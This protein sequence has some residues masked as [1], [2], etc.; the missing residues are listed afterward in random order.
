MFFIDATTF[1]YGITYRIPIDVHSGAP[2]QKSRSGLRPVYIYC[3]RLKARAGRRRV[4]TGKIGRQ[5]ADYS[6]SQLPRAGQINPISPDIERCYTFTPRLAFATARNVH[7]PSEVRIEQHIFIV[8]RLA[9]LTFYKCKL[10]ETRFGKKFKIPISRFRL[11]T[12]LQ[13]KQ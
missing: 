9:I 6:Y 5:S 11:K 10:F 13:N 7:G 2:P 4:I 12:Y 1:G 3:E 8:Q